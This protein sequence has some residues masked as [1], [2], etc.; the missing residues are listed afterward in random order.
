[1]TSFN[2]SV[3]QKL[4]KLSD[5]QIQKLFSSISSERDTLSSIIEFLSLGLVVL[6]K[7]YKLLLINKAA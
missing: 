4:S 7:D 5:S 3:A 1:M 2:K 6:D